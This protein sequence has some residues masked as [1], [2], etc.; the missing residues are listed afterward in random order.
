MPIETPSTISAFDAATKAVLDAQYASA[1]RIVNFVRM[2]VIGVLAVIAAAWGSALPLELNLVNVGVLTP[3]LVWSVGQH[4]LVHRNPA[5]SELLSFVNPFLDIT[6]VTAL[7]LGYGLFGTPDLA[8]KS[9]IWAAYFIILAGR[10]ITSSPRRAGLAALVAT[11]QY[12]AIAWFF[13]GT[14]RLAVLENPLHSVSVSGTTLLDEAAKV[15][16]LG[17]AGIVVM[18]ATTWNERT[19]R[20]SV[21]SMRASEGRFRAIFEHAAVGIAVLDSGSAILETNG[22]FAR[23]LGAPSDALR[24]KKLS[25]FASAEDVGGA[26]AILEGVA[27]GTRANATAELRFV[28]PDGE[29]AW[30]S[31]TV[32]STEDSKSRR[33]VAM[34]GDAT[35]RKTLEAQL[36]HQAFHDPLTELANRVLF[37]NRVEHA[38]ARRKGEAEAIAVLFLDL[39]NFKTVND[40][41]GHAA[42]DRL[43][44]AVAERLLSATRGCDTVAR[45]GGDEFAVLLEPVH[46]GGGPDIVAD[47]I[48]SALRR[49]IETGNGR[50]VTVG[51]S[52]GIASST[53]HESPDVLLRNADLAMYEAKGRCRGG[54]LHFDP[55]M[56]ASLMN[57]V[58]LE[59]DLREAI[60]Q[61]Q[62]KL[63][64]QP[65][66][67]LASGR[68]MAFEALLRWTHPRR[69]PVAPN[70]FIPV[71]EECGVILPL[72]RW[73]LGTACKQAA[74]WNARPGATPVTITVNL[75]GKQI[76]QEELTAEVA[77]ALNQSGLAPECLLLEITET[78]I[79]HETEQTLA[80][81]NELKQLG[82]R[83]AIDDF[84]TGYSSLSYLQQFPVDVL[85]IDRSFTDALLRGPN[86]TALVRTIIAL[87]DMLGLKSVAEGVEDSQQKAQLRLLGCDSGQGFL[88][89]H[90]VDAAG[91]ML[92]LESE[93]DEAVATGS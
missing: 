31:V 24:G 23:F 52:L 59:A 41:Q 9:P 78:V 69:G 11:V 51:A 84:G 12:A 49:P 82:V 46:S 22:A 88:F 61:D 33:L 75:S 67:D 10:A 44:R 54:W 1:E 55:E 85:K 80:R 42:G 48:V 7:L 89:G 20:R 3:M 4:L 68:I 57:R 87:A 15:V 63:L 92:L 8:V 56:H 5:P 79:M 36:L 72:G 53:G 21:E 66:V 17:V 60:Q 83:L 38:L 73:V 34:V 26:S 70:T 29:V 27:D 65:I 86:E 16:L 91:V 32:S 93:F 62:L 64:Y 43:L 28:R 81:L 39:D 37:R 58:T 25:N 47:R 40:T 71:A 14:G 90:P 13:T 77:F 50:M 6:A 45:L 19:L 2:G 18:Y 30:G 76:Q 35:E 74:E